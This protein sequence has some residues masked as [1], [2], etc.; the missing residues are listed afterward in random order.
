MN[1]IKQL[2]NRVEE[3][4]TEQKIKDDK[5]TAMLFYLGLPKFWEDTTVQVSDMYVRL[6]DL[7]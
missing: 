2:Q 6:L 5:I 4:E 3:L 7:R 1:Y